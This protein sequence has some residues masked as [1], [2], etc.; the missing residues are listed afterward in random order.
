MSMLWLR[1]LVWLPALIASSAASSATFA[2]ARPSPHVVELTLTAAPSRLSLLPGECTGVFAYNGQVPGPTLEFR[3]GDHVVIHF[4]NELPEVTTIHWHGLHIPAAMDGSPLEPVKPG[5]SYDYVFDIPPGSAGTYWYHPHPD[6]RSGYQVAKGLYGALIIRAADD[7]LA[8]I[9]EKLLVLSDNRFLPNGEV[10]VPPPESPQGEIDEENGREGPD[11]FVSGQIMPTISIRSGEV[12]RWRVVN[13]SAARYYRLALAGHEFLQVGTDGG[14][15]EH[16]VPVNEIILAPA[17]RAELLVRATGAPGARAELRTMPYDHYVPQTRPKDWNVPR[18]LLTLQ[19]TGQP[20]VEPVVLP[21]R[22][23]VVPPL[24]TMKAAVRR[25]IVFSQGLINGRT[26]DMHRVDEH[27]RLGATEIWQIENVVGMDHPFHLHGFQ[28]QVLDRNGVPEPFRAWRDM[29]NVP[30]H[31]RVRI[32]VRFHD[33]P[34][35]WM[36]HCHILDHEDEGM[37]G[38]LEVSP[39][40]R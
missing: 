4:H 30:K 26:M 14:L 10:D 35:K 6:L 13:A 12:Q 16:P 11:L 5:G 23:R 37:M 32:I 19:Y 33:Y 38:I 36:Y 39:T 20:P 28:F 40:G 2:P 25:V 34:G 3:E 17:E 31:E 7:P 18:D 1:G 29:V 21:T 24:D 9:P 15:F 22:L 8:G 27:A